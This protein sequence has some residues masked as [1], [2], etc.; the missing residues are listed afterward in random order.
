MCICSSCDNISA[1]HIV[2]VPLY[3]YILTKDT[4]DPGEEGAIQLVGGSR[5]SEGR[6]EIFY[7]G[8]WGTV[9]NWNWDINDA[10]VVCRQLGYP[11][12]WQLLR[13]LLT[14]PQWNL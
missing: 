2:A 10:M 8:E 3:T 5:P 11:G 14:H 12:K 7:N 4:H 9:C 6:I 13:R 1:S